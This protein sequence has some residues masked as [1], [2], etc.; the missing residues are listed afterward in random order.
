MKKNYAAAFGWKRIVRSNSEK[1]MT[2]ARM[3]SLVLAVSLLSGC[4]TRNRATA[5]AAPPVTSPP[6]SFFQGFA[7]RDREAARKF[8]KKHLELKGVSVAAS[9]EVSDAALERT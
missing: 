4:A 8:Y 9:G 7:E 3:A 1:G 2:A 6:E 5:D